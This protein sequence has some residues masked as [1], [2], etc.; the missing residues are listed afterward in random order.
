MGDECFCTPTTISF[1]DLHIMMQANQVKILSTYECTYPESPALGLGLT[2]AI[3]LMIAQIVINVATGCVCCRKGPHQ[4]NAD[5][6][7]A[8]TCFFVS[9]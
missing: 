5:W 1:D 9:W 3:A 8:L 2:S 4:S 7:L 6:S